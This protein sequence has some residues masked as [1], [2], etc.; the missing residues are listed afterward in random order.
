MSIA[1]HER[2]S[3]ACLWLLMMFVVVMALGLLPCLSFA[4]DATSAPRV[5]PVS[6][7]AVDGCSPGPFIRTCGGPKPRYVDLDLPVEAM[8]SETMAYTTCTIGTPF[9][10]KAFGTSWNFAS[11]SPWVSAKVTD[12]SHGDGCQSLITGHIHVTGSPPPD[13]AGFVVAFQVPYQIC[14]KVPNTPENCWSA[15]SGNSTQYEYVWSSA[16]IIARATPKPKPK[17]VLKAY[18]V[19]YSGSGARSETSSSTRAAVSGSRTVSTPTPTSEPSWKP[20]TLGGGTDDVINTSALPALPGKSDSKGHFSRSPRRLTLTTKNLLQSL[21]PGDYSIP[22]VIK[23]H[24][25]L[26]KP[27]PEN[28]AGMLGSLLLTAGTGPGAWMMVSPSLYERFVPSLG[29]MQVRVLAPVTAEGILGLSAADAGTIGAA[30]AT[31]VA[32]GPWD[33]VVVVGTAVT[34]YAV[35]HVALSVPIDTS[36]DEASKRDKIG[37]YRLGMSFESPTRLERQSNDA[38]EKGVG[39]FRLHIHGVSV[40]MESRGY[41]ESF[42]TGAEILR[43]FPII[44]TPTR[45]DPTHCTIK[46]PSPVTKADAYNFNVLIFKRPL[47]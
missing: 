28:E 16:P 38:L 8:I 31:G 35:D 21:K 20:I 22:A 14:A 23:P 27:H 11:P 24:E 47:R 13:S 1:P 26:K 29:A 6:L 41:D 12:A 19:T 36:L 5:Q 39:T 30:G 44:P 34:L 37:F 33:I 15:N 42:A 45:S 46:L 10:S 32:I 17:L 40:S 25:S 4:Q 2:R 7:A 9:I 3:C 18:L 43:F